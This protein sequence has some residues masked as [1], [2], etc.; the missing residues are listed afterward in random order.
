MSR[1][2]LALMIAPVSSANGRTVEANVDSATRWYREMREITAAEPIAIICP[3][4]VGI[5]LGD[6]DSDPEQRRRALDESEAVAARCDF[7]IA[8]GH[9]EKLSAG[10][11]REESACPGPCVDLLHLGREYDDPRWMGVERRRE[12][13]EQIREVIRAHRSARGGRRLE[14]LEELAEGAASA[15]DEVTERL[16]TASLTEERAL[17][18]EAYRMR[19]IFDDA[20]QGEHNV[21]ALVDHYQRSSMEADE[22]LTV[23]EDDRRALAAHLR[24]LLGILDAVGGYLTADY[25]AAIRAARE[26][27][28]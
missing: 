4:L 10:M 11:A 24:T 25:Q 21:L 17:A 15:R 27:V 6:Q 19:K 26:A 13:R 28:G 20:G 9:A 2:L 7:T 8:V 23:A 14:E 18:A 22:R 16:L 3:C 5:L 12:I 1:P